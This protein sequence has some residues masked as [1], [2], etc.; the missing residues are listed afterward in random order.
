MKLSIFSIFFFLI[1]LISFFL[2]V[3]KF[4]YGSEENVLVKC[5]GRWLLEKVAYKFK[6]FM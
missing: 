3:G 1:S 4:V 5:F 2:K 6:K